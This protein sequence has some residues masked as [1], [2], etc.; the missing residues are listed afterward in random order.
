MLPEFI[1]NI[2]D[3]T[4]LASTCRILRVTMATAMPKQI[5]RLAAASSKI[6]FRP[7]PLFLVAATAKELGNWARWG[8]ANEWTLIREGFDNGF[9][10]LLDL[11][12]QH[13]GLTME[14]IRKLHL[15]RFSVINPVVDIIDRFMGAQSCGVKGR[16]NG[17]SSDGGE[18]E[19]DVCASTTTFH[20][21]IYGELFGPDIETTLNRHHKAGRLEVE[22]RSE[23][24]EECLP[25]YEA[26]L[27]LRWMVLSSRWKSYWKEMRT[28]AGGDFREGFSG[29][30]P[31]PSEETGPDG[32]RQRFWENAMI[33]QG[34]EGLG[35]TLPHSRSPWID[36][37]RLWRG[38]I[39]KLKKEPPSAT[40]DDHNPS[41]RYPFL[42][43]DLKA[44]KKPN[45]M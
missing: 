2:E 34:L 33:C 39:S 31:P 1:H 25:S 32:W 9:P 10:G 20:F 4:N 42:L 27:A 7:D 26:N 23:F 38:K 16:W 13:C 44:W 45:T 37:V 30:W 19:L 22:T 3:Y 36:R 11:E 18:H 8:D 24:V 43:G 5:L 40:V 12:L 29:D 35:M 41:I 28:L 14:R 17:V 15:L 6:F 21:V